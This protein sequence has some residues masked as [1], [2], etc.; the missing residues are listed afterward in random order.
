MEK[1]KVRLFG[2]I[3]DIKKVGHVKKVEH[4]MEIQDFLVKKEVWRKWTQALQQK[5]SMYAKW[6]HWILSEF[7][8]YNERGPVKN[9]EFIDL[10]NKD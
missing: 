1:E 9:S 2:I 6:F 3:E 5:V 8:S 7:T 10:M 4:E